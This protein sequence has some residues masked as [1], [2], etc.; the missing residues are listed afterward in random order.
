MIF[1]AKKN[2]RTIILFKDVMHL[3]TK[4]SKSEDIPCLQIRTCEPAQAV[5]EP[6]ICKDI[7]SHF[8]QT[9]QGP[10]YGAAGWDGHSE[11]SSARF[12]DGDRTKRAFQAS[13]VEEAAAASCVGG[14]SL[15]TAAARYAACHSCLNSLTDN[16]AGSALEG[17]YVDC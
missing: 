12:V 8:S 2:T 6:P 15:G 4:R 7:S 5:V 9:E 11:L 13:Y 1:K 10:W 14:G 3:L 16:L 17:S